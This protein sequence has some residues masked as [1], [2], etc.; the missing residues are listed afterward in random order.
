MNT[1]G[2]SCKDFLQEPCEKSARSRARTLQEP[3][4]T[5]GISCKNRARSR[6]RTSEYQRDFL[7]EPC[8]K[9]RKNHCIPK[10]FLAWFLQPFG[11]HWFLHGLFGL[12]HGSCKEFRWYSMVHGWFL[13]DMVLP[14]NPFSIHWF[15]DVQE[16]SKN[17]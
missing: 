16:P 9:S 1:K 3:V 4:N 6:A 13:H 17:H 10:G 14:R 7:Q 15:Y 11:I 12:T 2:I 8:E 5:K